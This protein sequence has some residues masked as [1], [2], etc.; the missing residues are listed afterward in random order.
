MVGLLDRLARR[1]VSAAELRAAAHGRARAV[2]PELNA[3]DVLGRR[4][5]RPASRPTGPLAG[6]PTLVKDNEAARRLPDL[7]RVELRARPARAR[8][9]RRGSRTR[10]PSGSRPI[11]KTTLSEF[12]LTATT[13]TRRVRRD[14]QPVGHRPLRAAGRAA[15]RR[16]S[17]PPASCRSAH[18]ND[19][20]GSIRIP[21]SCCGLVGLKPTRGRLPDLDSR[22]RSTSPSRAC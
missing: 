22:C 21:A 9:A 15:A 10:W 19:G 5:R 3:V 8:R 11:A 17:S 1:E 4:R 2:Q 13:E 18:G 6:V 20:G 12:G 7:E 14:P 16:R